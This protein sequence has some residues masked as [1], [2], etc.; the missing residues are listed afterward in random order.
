MSY[1]QLKLEEL[2]VKNTGEEIKLEQERFQNRF[3]RQNEVIDTLL[4][5]IREQEALLAK[6]AKAHPVALEHVHFM[7]PT[8]LREKMNSF[9]TLYA[10]LKDD[11]HRYLAKW[12]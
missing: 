3:I 10:D 1:F 2:A 7:N 11:F 5:E 6:F 9:Y 4:H 8:N 12:M